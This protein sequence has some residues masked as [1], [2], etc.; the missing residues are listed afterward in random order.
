MVEVEGGEERLKLAPTIAHKR[1][2][3]LILKCF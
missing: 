3:Q 2:H 1:N